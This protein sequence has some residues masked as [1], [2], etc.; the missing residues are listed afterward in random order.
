MLI[1]NELS[2]IH[3]KDMAKI[4]EIYSDTFNKE[5][6]ELKDFYDSKLGKSNEHISGLRNENHG[7]NF[8]LGEAMSAKN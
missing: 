5:L 4:K 3:H 6:A 1:N 2:E 7:I 8:K